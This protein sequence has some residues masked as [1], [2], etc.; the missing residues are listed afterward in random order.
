[1][2]NILLVLFVAF[3]FLSCSHSASNNANIE[4]KTI[5]STKYFDSLRFTNEK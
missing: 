5:D 1:M 4:V 2:K 3:Q